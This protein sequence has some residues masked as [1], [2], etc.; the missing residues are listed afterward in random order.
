MCFVQISTVGFLVIGFFEKQS[1][2]APLVGL[3]LPY[4]PSWTQTHQV[5]CL[6][7][8]GAGIKNKTQKV[9]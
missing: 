9:F 5:A 3:E 4:G 7:L 2:N 1:H 8:Q 6:C